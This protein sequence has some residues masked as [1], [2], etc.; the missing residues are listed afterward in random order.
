MTL[1]DPPH[2]QILLVEV[3]LHP[4]LIADYME[5]EAYS[6]WVTM[7]EAAANSAGVVFW[8]MV[9]RALIPADGWQ[10]PQHLN[11]T[12]ADVF[13]AW[14]GD[15]VGKAVS[16]GQLTL[17]DMHV[18][19]ITSLDFAGFTILVLLV[20]Y[21]LP[22]RPQNILL[23]GVSYLFYVTW[24]W[25]YALVLAIMTL[26]NFRAGSPPA[27]RRSAAP[28]AALDRDRRESGGAGDF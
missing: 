25:W 2:Q 22:R 11:T 16:Q 19:D 8:P 9:D 5:L 28:P 1:H 3:P 6:A 10:D 17:K 26:I 27:P 23:L 14:L 12:G 18:M 21:L 20:Y 13:S 4:I 7:I 24:S 15:Q